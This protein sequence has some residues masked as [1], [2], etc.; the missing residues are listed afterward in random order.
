[1]Y[2]ENDSNIEY[3]IYCRKSSDETSDNQKQS[4]PDQIRAC[5]D[6]AK[7]EKLKIKEKPKDFSMFESEGEID[8][9]NKEPDILNNRI[10]KDTRH[11]FIVKEEKTGKIPGAREKWKNIIKLVKKGQ[12]NG[13]IS[14]SPDRQARNMLEGGELIDLVDKNKLPENKEKGLTILDLKYTN[15][16]FQDNAAGKMMLGIWFVFSKQ[17]S[18][19]LAED[20]ARGNQNKVKSGKG[21]GIYKHGYFINEQGYHEPDERNFPLIKEAFMMKLDGEPELNILEFL[22]ANGYARYYKKTK[23]FRSMNKTSLNNMFKDEFYYGMLVN[24]DTI[25]DLRDNLLNPYYK[26]IITE[27]QYQILQDRYYN[28]PKVANKSVT[29]DEHD[30]IKVYSTDFILTEDGY[31]MTFNIPNKLRHRKKIEKEAQKGIHLELKDVIS[32]NQI[33][34]ECKRKESKYYLTRIT[35]E[36]IDKEVLNALSHF[37]VGEKE[38]N[39]Y[40]SFTNTE[41]DKI[42]LTTKEKISRKNLEI[43]RVQ[44]QR[45]KFIKDNMKF[46]KEGL[47]GEIYQK[48]VDSYNG[49]IQFLRKEIEA[50]DE[51]ERNQILELEIF[52][53]VLNNAKE[54]Y[55]KG[56]YVQKGKI[57]SILFSNILLNNKKRLQ[58]QVKPGLETLF[59]PI[60]WS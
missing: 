34:Y 31:G 47:E 46:K 56:N 51:G 26:A 11:L 16:H 57:V 37:K 4:I 25:T 27:E 7:R 52:I 15:F 17:Y 18:D 6:Y 9:E 1:M 48:E 40:V 28:N 29:K 43:S 39:E 38:F 30:D 53:N 10:F 49:K 20:I 22:N 44:N 13:I 32:P 24:G 42:N 2:N 14:Y 21:I 8:K 23:E 41:L 45:N 54:Y 36:D 5:V 3:V 59:N 50:L 58:L 19:K 33:I 35:Q 55:K 60:W 12:I